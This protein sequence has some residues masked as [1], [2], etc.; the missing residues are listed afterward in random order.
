L[1][2]GP[3]PCN[4]C[5]EHLEREG[6][7]SKLRIAALVVAGVVVLS[8]AI[9]AIVAWTHGRRVSR[10]EHA[11]TAPTHGAFATH[12]IEHLPGPARRYLSHSIREGTPLH[13]SVE[14][15]QK[16]WMKLDPDRPH[17]ELDS[18]EKLTPGVGF[19]W[20]ARARMKGIRIRITDHYLGGE[21]AVRVS[22]LGL[23]PVVNERGPDVARSGRGRLAAESPWCPTALVD[24]GSVRWEEV[25]DDS[26]RL[27]QT[28]DGED[29]A[30]TLEVDG[31]GRLTRITM[32]RHGNEG[33]DDWGPTPYGFDVLDEDTFGGVTVPTVLRGGWWYGTDR[34]DRDAASRFEVCE[35]D[36]P[37]G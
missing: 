31:E 6:R 8:I 36:F 27:V 33:R 37:N 30:I 10:V 2:T 13:R 18:T 21:A 26:V 5:R 34:Y 12:T 17:V 35:L 11:L 28:V 32:Q 29:V 19:L 23:L 16:S 24:S 1:F 4:L 14:L 3:A 7:V 9:V 25:D 15:R 20:H 22:V